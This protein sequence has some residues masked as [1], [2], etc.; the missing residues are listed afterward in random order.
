MQAF[1][2]LRFPPVIQALQKEQDLA[3][4]D[5]VVMEQMLDLVIFFMGEIQEDDAI[6][7]IQAQF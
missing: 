5:A 3:E 2:N 4:V 1:T 6:E 7:F